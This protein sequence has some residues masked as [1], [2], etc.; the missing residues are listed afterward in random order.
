MARSASLTWGE[1]CPCAAGEG[2]ARR[3]R[4]SHLPGVADRLLASRDGRSRRLLLVLSVARRATECTSIPNHQVRRDRNGRLVAGQLHRVDIPLIGR[5][6]AV[7]SSRRLS[8]PRWALMGL[9]GALH[10]LTDSPPAGHLG[11]L[12]HGVGTARM[13]RRM[14]WIR[15]SVKVTPACAVK[16]S[17]KARPTM[18]CSGGPDGVL[19]TAIAAPNDW[20]DA[21]VEFRRV[22]EQRCHGGSARCTDHGLDDA[23][24]TL[25]RVEEG[26]GPV[27]GRVERGHQFEPEE[28]R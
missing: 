6:V 24:E 14:R 13:G 3:E 17:T 26:G 5:T 9:G 1:W 10:A 4:R 18:R 28:Q 20:N 22:L 11:G 2:D 15:R 8:S 21:L 16:P 23:G 7:G 27:P 19:M 12:S 25:D